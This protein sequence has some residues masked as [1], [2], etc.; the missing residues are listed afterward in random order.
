MGRETLWDNRS[1]NHAMMRRGLVVCFLA[2]CPCSTVLPVAAS[3]VDQEPLWQRVQLKTSGYLNLTPG[4]ITGQ[5]HVPNYSKIGFVPEADVELT[6]QV[7]D[8]GGNV[9]AARV[10]LNATGIWLESED[11]W[12]ASVGEASVFA[13]GRF[14]RIELGERAGFPQTLLGYAPSE[15]TFT[16][17]EVGPEAGRRLDPSGRLPTAFFSRDLAARIDAQAFR[18]YAVRF[19]DVRSPKII[20]VSPRFH[21]LYG[22]LSYTPRTVKPN[23]VVVARTRP[24][25]ASSGDGFG[26]IVPANSFD[27]LVQSALVYQHR[28][29]SADVSTGLTYAYAQPTDDSSATGDAHSLHGGVRATL[30]DAI[31]LGAS[32]T[33]DGLSQ[34]RDDLAPRLRANPFGVVGSADYVLGPWVAGGYYQYAVGPSVATAPGRD[35]VQIFELGLAYLFDTHDHFGEGFYTN[36][37]LF[38]S[39]YYYALHETADGEDG[40]RSDGHVFLVG[41]SFSFF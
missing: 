26:P 13:I 20:Y 2:L 39:F 12:Q 11:T 29:E 32:A 25:P 35:R 9:F 34:D 3:A 5:R 16:T 17:I 31:T 6:P 10:T 7:R 33:Y 30:Q 28:T 4:V 41:T 19:Y 18:G 27:N 1:S 37:K 23:E 14:G 21:G 22:A 8:A 24:R 36:L 40:D 15:I 38:S